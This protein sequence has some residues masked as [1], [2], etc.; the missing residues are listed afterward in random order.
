M[1]LAD[2][3]RS[4]W[5]D[6]GTRGRLGWVTASPACSLM[7]ATLPLFDA[8]LERRL[9]GAGRA[10]LQTALADIAN[11]AAAERLASLISMASRHAPRGDLD[12]SAAERNDA[13]R[14]LPGWNPERWT[15]LEA[16]RARLVLNHPDIDG[17][18][19]SAVLEEC[20]RYADGGELTALYRVLGHLP[21]GERF[22]WRAAEGCR[23]N[24]R[25]V[26]EATACDTPYPAQYFDDVAWHQLVIKAVFI[27]A[28]LWRVYGL[29]RRLSPELARMALDLADERRSAG[30]AVQPELW[31]CLG[32]HG[33]QR[34]LDA[35]DHEMS[36]ADRRSRLAA[37]LAL[38]RA[39]ADDRARALLGGESDPGVKA[40]LESALAGRCDQSAFAIFET[41]SD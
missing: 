2:L 17:A 4:G 11:G 40:T 5:P 41:G 7:I 34:A 3:V 24:M 19:F 22:A 31:L 18:S 23:T 16:L 27:E 39:G 15:T 26:F 35:L 1:A 29:D 28:P 33:G 13:Q 9:A 10:W 30:R 14:L 25:T 12:P 21:A 8:L 36:R 20:F 38:G 6:P 32:T 37:A